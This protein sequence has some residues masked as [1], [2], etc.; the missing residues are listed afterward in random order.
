[1]AQFRRAY[2]KPKL[3][4]EIN[5]EEDIRARV[6]GTVIEK[7]EDSIVLDDGT[8]SVEV[9]LDSANLEK[10]K[11]KDNLRIFGRILPYPDGFEIQAEVVQNMNNLNFDLYKKIKEKFGVTL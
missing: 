9:F 8:K 1:M 11:E 2:A 5:P 10:I 3:I 7:R 4:N 6:F